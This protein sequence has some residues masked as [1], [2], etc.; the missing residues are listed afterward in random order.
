MYYAYWKNLSSGISYNLV[1]TAWK[2]S[3]CGIVWQ[4]DTAIN[5]GS[6][7]TK[8]LIYQQ[9]SWTGRQILSSEES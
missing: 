8:T 6:G 1:M 7:I 3:S 5:Q 9:E 4:T 2:A